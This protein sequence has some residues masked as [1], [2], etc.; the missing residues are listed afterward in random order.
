MWINLSAE[1]F[2]ASNLLCSQ[3]VRFFR[4]SNFRF[5]SI[6]G[7]VRKFQ[8]ALFAALCLGGRSARRQHAT[9]RLLRAGE[10]QHETVKAATLER[11]RARRSEERLAPFDSGQ[12]GLKPLRGSLPDD[13]K[14]PGVPK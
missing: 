13:I 11:E 10:V 9:E 3:H 14:L 2:G 4:V 7:F 12:R 6:A 8:V 1:K 5:V